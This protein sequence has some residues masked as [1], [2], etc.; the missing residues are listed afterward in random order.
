ML[1]LVKMGSLLIRL[2]PESNKTPL[3][4]NVDIWAKEVVM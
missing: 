3:E 4:E 1:W 2:D